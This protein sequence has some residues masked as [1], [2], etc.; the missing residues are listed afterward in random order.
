MV[1]G[2]FP[3]QLVR[4]ELRDMGVAAP[5]EPSRDASRADVMQ[6]LWRD[7]GLTGIELRVFEIQ[8]SYESFEE[9]WS[10]VLGGPATSAVLRTMQPAQLDELQARV[11]NRL[12]PD[13]AG[14]ITCGARATGIKGHVSP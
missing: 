4:D 13:S 3:Y 7:A 5:D 6:G 9:Y 8:R 11:R 2:G 14:R 10:I 12:P 1:G